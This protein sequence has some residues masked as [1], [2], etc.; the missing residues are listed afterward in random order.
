MNL[1]FSVGDEEKNVRE[2]RKRFFAEVDI[3]LTRIALPK[4]IHSDIVRIVTEPAEYEACDALITKEKNLFLVITIADCLPILLF[5]PVTSS[6]GIVHA[7]WRGSEMRILSKVVRVL[8]SEFG[9][10][11]KNLLA[12]VGPSAGVCCYEV[13]EEVAEKFDMK[14]LDRTKGT[15]PH[16]DLKQF[17]KDLRLEAGIQK[18]NIEVSPDCTICKPELYHS[19]RR[20]KE[21][22]GRMMAGIGMM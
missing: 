17:N 4:Q 19:Y 18:K 14:Y 15:K 16:L 13:G 1:S 3:P 10:L 22:S 7:G 20:D 9:V 8:S 6:I 12:Y 11:S 5:D 2:N 21:K